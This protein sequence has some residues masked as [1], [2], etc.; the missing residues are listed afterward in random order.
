MIIFR[1]QFEECFK[2]SIAFSVSDK[3]QKTLKK[4]WDIILCNNWIGNARQFI[5]RC[6]YL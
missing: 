5:Q 1:I 3:K 6:S 4:R 2:R